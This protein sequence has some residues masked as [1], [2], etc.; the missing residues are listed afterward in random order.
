MEKTKIDL[1]KEQLASLA[2]PHY[3]YSAI[4][5]FFFFAMDML[6]G[7]R[8]TL[9]KTKLLEILACIPYRTWEGYQY[10]RMTFNYSDPQIV[11]LAG[12]I[13]SWGREAQDSEYWHLLAVH[14]KMKEDGV[15]DP[16]FLSTP[17]IFL[18][19]MSYVLLTWIVARININRAF[20]FN[21][22]FEDHAEHIYAE[23]VADHPEWENQPVKSS[24]VKNY[25]NFQ[26][27]AEVFQSIAL[28]ERDHMNNS[29]IFCGR[30]ECVVKYEGMPQTP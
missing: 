2:R 3:N 19:V 1:K 13:V 26:N 14:E 30:P 6:V 5:R 20:L 22:E 11:Q 9:P 4:A 23:F 12:R 8:T 25:K 21:A 18:M 28:D 10:K 24:L 15:N 29:F 17:I 27:W 16:W 7:K